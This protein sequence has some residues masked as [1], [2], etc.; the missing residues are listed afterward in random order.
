M[1]GSMGYALPVAL[2][3]SLHCRSKVFC[4]DGDGSLIMRTG[5]LF[6]A[7]AFSKDNL[8]Y[9]LLDNGAHESTGAQA[10][11]SGSVQFDKLAEASGFKK[12]VFTNDVKQVE[13]ALTLATEDKLLSF[14][15]IKTRLGTSKEISRPTLT[16]EE[17]TNRF[18]QG[19]KEDEKN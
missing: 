15:H 8:V 17:I 18:K 7:G 19:I 12:Y 11:I 10:T 9:I 1:Q 5:N 16:P 6:T 3:V 2:G 13:K 4:L 14:L